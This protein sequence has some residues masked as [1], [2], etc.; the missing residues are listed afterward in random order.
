MVSS[1][2]FCS[3]YEQAVVDVDSTAACCCISTQHASIGVDSMA[4]GWLSS[5]VRVL[6]WRDVCLRA[7]GCCL[8]T[9]CA[10]AVQR[11]SDEVADLTL[12]RDYACELSDG[13]VLELA[14]MREQM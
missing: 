13:T 4:V 2:I 12:V 7:Q 10:H 14:T 1:L 3:L 5:C 8:A 6:Y 11:S 9:G